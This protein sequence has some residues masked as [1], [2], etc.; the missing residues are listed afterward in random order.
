MNYRNNGYF[1]IATILLL[2]LQINNNAKSQDKKEVPPQRLAIII[3]TAL[4]FQY[5]NTLQQSSENGTP[6]PLGKYSTS[7]PLAVRLQIDY[8][9][10]NTKK[11]RVLLSPF[12]ETGIFTPAS[13][14]NI[15]GKQ[16]VTGVPVKTRFGFN[17][18]RI[19][20]SN[21]QE[22]GRFK[23]F[24]IGGTL[25]IR[26]WQASFESA[27]INTANDNIIIVPLLFIGY[28]KFITPK[29]FFN[30]EIDGLIVPFASVMEGGS[31]LN[32]AITKNISA[33][34]Q[35]RVLAG[36][37]NSSDVKNKFITQNIGLNACVQF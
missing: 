31:S 23:N 7:K 21:K 37:Y 25:A 18:L 1:K 35:Y 29:L 34:F 22:E 14:T 11:I 9:L 26:K 2:A 30:T 20:F 17:V 6:I 32:Y 5:Y 28:E 13:T 8:Y 3:G 12:N 10:S 15:E 36:T 4:G 24:K 27:N 33:G 16:F 19:G